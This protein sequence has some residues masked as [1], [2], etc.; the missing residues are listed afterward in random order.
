MQEPLESPTKRA[1]KVDVQT[2]SFNSQTLT[3]LNTMNDTVDVEAVARLKQVAHGSLLCK[4][5]D[6]AT[7]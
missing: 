1:T 7:A 5:L 2:N 4:V 6:T 3:E